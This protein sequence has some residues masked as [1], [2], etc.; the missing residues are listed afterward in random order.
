MFV[1]WIGDHPPRHVHVWRDG[2]EVV[3]WDLDEGRAITG[4]AS[5]RVRRLLMELVDEGRL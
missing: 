2:V 1:T 5:R 4:R 3:V